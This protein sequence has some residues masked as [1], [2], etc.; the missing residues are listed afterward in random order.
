MNRNLNFGGVVSVVIL[1]ALAA[2]A[3]AG[4]WATITVDEWP[5]EI[6]ANEPVLIG[7]TVRQH[8]RDESRLSGINPTVT[9]KNSVTGESFVVHA[10]DEGPAG[11]YVAAITF[12]EQGGWSWSIQ[13]FGMDQP[14]PPLMVIASLTASVSQ[15]KPPVGSGIFFT[16]GLAIL[17]AV[18]GLA[19][20]ALALVLVWRKRARWALALMVVGLLAVAVGL[21]SAAGQPAMKAPQ[22]IEPA[23]GK[24]AAEKPLTQG[25]FGKV[26]FIAKGC[27]TCHINPEIE[28][29]YTPLR[30]DI[31]KDLTG[32]VA[33]PEFLRMWLKDPKSI[34]PDTEMPNLE[35]SQAEIEALIAFINPSTEVK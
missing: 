21:A 1:L 12:P 23:E 10:K 11:H 15:V 2:P 26:L 19:V 6:S 34:K 14:M 4:G 35:L 20:A 31:G 28:A 33:A 17:G 8:G 16:P 5:A 25:E 30:I 9:A 22:A 27:A 18:L 3:L 32:Y 24:P 13:A 29:A 7:F